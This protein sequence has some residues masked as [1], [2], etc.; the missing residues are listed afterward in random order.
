MGS[1]NTLNLFDLDELIMLFSFYWSNEAAKR[2]LDIGPILVC[3]QL[4]WVNA[5][6]SQEL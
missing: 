1:V 6:R 4:F 2:V 5:A 3:I